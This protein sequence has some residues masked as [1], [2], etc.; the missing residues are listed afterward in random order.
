MNGFIRSASYLR[1]SSQRQ[2]DEKTIES[3]QADVRDRA[4]QDDLAIDS[5]FEY[6]DDGY[7][8]S[9]LLRPAL[10]RLRD[11]VAASMI[12]RLYV[13]SPDRLARNFA[14]QAILLEEMSKH[15][16]EVIFLN[17]AGLP[18]SPET[19]M[20]IQMQGMFAEY[21]RAKILERTRR[22]R[23]HSAS[24]GN[25][26]VFGRAPYGY[27]YIP[28]VAPDSEASWEV[29]PT[30]GDIVRC[31]FKLVGEKGYTL[32]AVCRELKLRGIPSRKGNSDWDR[33][34][35]RGILTNPAYFGEARY[36][37]KRLAQRK[38]G[39]RAKRGD[40]AVPRQAKVAVATSL[41]DQIMIRV[42]AMVS[43]T[44]FTEVRKRMDENRTRQRQ[45]QDGP[46][47]L[48]SGFLICG[49]CGSAYCKHGSERY[50][51]YRCIGTDRFR[52]AGK[53]ICDNGSVKAD[54]LEQQ[55]WLD[56]CDLLRDPGRLQA[57]LQ[58]R[59]SAAPAHSDTNE[60]R[61]ASVDQL[62]DRINR[63]IDAYAD[64]L[65]ERHEFESRIGKLRSQHDRE[66]AALAS[67][68]GEQSA[69]SDWANA[70]TA[71]SRLASQVEANLETATFELKR[72]LLAL[73]ITRIEVCRSEIRIVYKVP[74][75]PFVPSPD[76]RGI[77]QHWLSLPA[78]APR[79]R[80][81]YRITRKSSRDRRRTP[82]P[83]D[84]LPCR[85][86]ASRKTN[87]LRPTRSR[88]PPPDPD[89]RSGQ[90]SKRSRR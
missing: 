8:G 59:Q 36:G 18:D 80:V 61:Q 4:T 71:L 78:A 24:K 44:L 74:P 48:L 37:K 43:Q 53:T 5:A 68:R 81:A 42:P 10:E 45:R 25:V 82:R 89:L 33:Q 75:N 79:L 22:G 46:K 3:Q 88:S 57:E 86:L 72:E 21:E 31:M 28:K 56:V 55:V 6:V 51:Y 47:H 7:S 39:R 41:E 14:H 17:Q 35:V 76:S 29:D 30:E 50:R 16:C 66:V 9:E 64:G 87:R 52:R 90:T 20:L 13:H 67:L 85:C 11:H 63:M 12:D 34:T 15:G 73:L 1:V 49:A 40:P 69:A 83:S 23:R 27:R 58:R 54:A 84:Q 60:K 65:L 38:P 26:S 32:A 70:A 2:T 77:F 19:K 62:R